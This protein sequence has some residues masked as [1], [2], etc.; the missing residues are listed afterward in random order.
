MV[1]VVLPLEILMEGYQSVAVAGLTQWM[2]EGKD[3]VGLM[4]LLSIGFGFGVDAD[5][6]RSGSIDADCGRF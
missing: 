5:V 6:R 3:S 4:D 2:V 1:V